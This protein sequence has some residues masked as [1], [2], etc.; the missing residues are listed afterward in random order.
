MVLDHFWKNAFF[1]PIFD[2]FLVPKK[3]VF[4]VFCDFPWPKS[5]TTGS[6]RPKNTV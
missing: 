6:K 3:P 4:K 1:T 2:P 5:A